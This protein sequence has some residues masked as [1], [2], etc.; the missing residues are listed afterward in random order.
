MDCPPI[1]EA[2]IWVAPGDQ[3]SNWIALIQRVNE[4]LHLSRVP[5]KRPLNLGDRDFIGVNPRQQ[6]ADWMLVY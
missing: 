5:Y 4:I 3:V 1:F 2:D 6:C